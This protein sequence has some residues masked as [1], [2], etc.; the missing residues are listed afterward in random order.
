[1]GHYTRKGE[2]E[3]KAEMGNWKKETWTRGNEVKDARW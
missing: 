2:F 3:D 1:M